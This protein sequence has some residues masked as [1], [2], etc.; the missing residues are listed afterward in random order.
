[1]ASASELRKFFSKTP[2]ATPPRITL[3]RRAKSISI[4][5]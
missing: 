4:D 3:I 5:A 2:R 1:M